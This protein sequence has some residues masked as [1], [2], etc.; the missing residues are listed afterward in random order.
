MSQERI[1]TFSAGPAVLPLHVVEELQQA[2]NLQETGIGLMEISHRSET[3][4]A[5]VDSAKARLQRVLSLPEDYEILFCKEEP[6][7][8][9]A[10]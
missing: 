10:W 3:F 2:L 8:S 4:G 7:C 6:P 9:S 1:L 5:I